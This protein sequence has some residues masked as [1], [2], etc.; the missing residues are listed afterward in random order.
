MIA[1]AQSLNIRSLM[2]I[3]KHDSSRDTDECVRELIRNDG[4]S[5]RKRIIG[6]WGRSLCNIAGNAFGY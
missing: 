1:D 3:T 6:Q 4:V 2:S 5:Y